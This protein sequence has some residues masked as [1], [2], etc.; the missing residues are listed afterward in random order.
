MSIEQDAQGAIELL[1][2]ETL[3]KAFAEIEADV[4]SLW[5]GSTYSDTET[6]EKLWMQLHALEMVKSKLQ[7]MVDGAKIAT[8]N[9]KLAAENNKQEN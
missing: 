4:L 2:S 1:K 9:A 7:S 8:A 3:K 5:R 6:R